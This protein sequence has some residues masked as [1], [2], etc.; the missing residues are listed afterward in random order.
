VSRDRVNSD[1]ARHDLGGKTF[2]ITGGNAGLGYFAGEQL[3]ARGARVVL[4][5]RNPQRGEAAL[6]AL[7]RQVPDADVLTVPLDLADL[8]SVHAAAAALSELGPI[9]GL[10]TNA[11]ATEG[12]ESQRTADGFELMFGTNHLGHFALIADLLP[13][14][15]ATK[16]SR[17][18][19][20]GSISHGFFSLDL[21]DPMNERGYQSFR[22]YGRSKLAVM[23]FGFELDRRL[24][25]AGHETQSLVAHPG[26]SIDQLTTD[27]RGVTPA[28]SAPAFAGRL[29]GGVIQGKDAG[30]R[31][32]V[33]AATDAYLRGGEYLGPS[34]WQQLTGG[35][36]VRRA[37]PRAHD[38]A[39][40]YRLWRLSE[41]LTGTRIEL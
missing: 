1:R 8:S 3:A 30:A 37:K 11:G 10:V 29:L 2:V 25:E 7:R 6:S 18:V 26:F 21:D 34:G 5:S 35:P 17:V 16:G 32:V 13:T 20:L 41:Q 38:I 19:H 36:A 12:K 33:R 9:H 22:A 23:V 39:I 31:P 4:T 14:L 15:L 28:G 24:R 27:R 40:A